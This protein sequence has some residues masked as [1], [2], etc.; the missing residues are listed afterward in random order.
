MVCRLIL[1]LFSQKHAHRWR[2]LYVISEVWDIFKIYESQT[3]W[4][5]LRKLSEEIDKWVPGLTWISHVKRK[6]ESKQKAYWPL[7]GFYSCQYMWKVHTEPLQSSKHLKPQKTCSLSVILVHTCNIFKRVT[8]CANSWFYLQITGFKNKI[9]NKVYR[10]GLTHQ[11][12]VCNHQKGLLV[13]CWHLTGTW[14][15]IFRRVSTIP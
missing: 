10:K 5:R 11:A 2:I 12:W 3:K 14:D 15:V 9:K 8:W 6:I 7:A 13:E 1:Y 4:T